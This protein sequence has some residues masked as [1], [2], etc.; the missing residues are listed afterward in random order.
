MDVSVSARATWK[1]ANWLRVSSHG[2]RLLLVLSKP[3]RGGG[4]Q[5]EPA[6]GVRLRT[7][8]RLA[9]AANVY[10]DAAGNLHNTS[11]SWYAKPP[12]RHDKSSLALESSLPALDAPTDGS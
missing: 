6:A 7:A 12:P 11:R 1:D 4:A 5:P 2:T 3:L 9:D 10:V 8:F